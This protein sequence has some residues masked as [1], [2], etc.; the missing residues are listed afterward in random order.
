MRT[1]CGC[2][3][4]FS[5]LTQRIDAGAGK[6][7]GLFYGMVGPDVESLFD[8]LAT[9][10]PGIVD[11][12]A[13]LRQ[14]E[15]PWYQTKQVE[16]VRVAQIRRRFIGDAQLPAIRAQLVGST[17]ARLKPRSCVRGNAASTEI[18]IAPTSCSTIPAAPCSLTL[19][20]RAVRFLPWTRSR[21][22]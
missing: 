6:T 11:V 3:P 5:N 2:R 9:G 15:Q 13:A 19:A 22:S 8:R 18:F 10:H 1:S 20:M 14:I 21:L 7:G 16:M 12:P 17:R 4:G